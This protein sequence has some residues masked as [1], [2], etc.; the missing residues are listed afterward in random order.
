MD[1]AKL[2]SPAVA[3]KIARFFHEHPAAVETARGMATWLACPAA[4][5]EPALETLAKAQVLTAHRSGPVTA[6]ALTSD[7]ALVQQ[8]GRV[9]RP[10]AD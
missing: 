3:S 1:L 4:E 6:Y 10:R 9:L 5:V 7:P 8:L 2:L